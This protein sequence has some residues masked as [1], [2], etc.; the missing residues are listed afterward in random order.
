M[1]SFG[2]SLQRVEDGEL[3]RGA[4]RFVDDHDPAREALHLVVARSAFAH[5]RV[6]LGAL[7]HRTGIVAVLGP[8]DVSHLGWPQLLPDLPRLRPLAVGVTR[9]QGEPLAAVVAE[10]PRRGRDAVMEIDVDYDVL[11]A[12]PDVPR[13]LVPGAPLV[14]EE[15]GSNIVYRDESEERPAAPPSGSVVVRREFTFPRIAPGMLEG[16]AFLAVPDGDGL[17]VYAGHQNAH[18][19]RAELATLLGL[20]EHDVAVVAPAVGG[21]FGAKSSFYPEYA[22]AAYA[23]LELGRPVKYVETR[24]EN[25]ML[26][27]HG[28]AQTQRVAVAADP[29]GRLVSLDVEVDANFGAAADIQ[30]WCIALTRRMLSGAYRIPRITWRM[31]GVLTHTAPLGAFRGAGRPE[32]AYL[33][34]RIVDELAREL[35]QDPVALRMANFVEP[36]AFPYRTP[37]GVTYDSGTYAAALEAAVEA[38][39]YHAWTARR[40]RRRTEGASRLLGVGVASYV[41]MTASGGEYGSVTLDG[42][43]RALVRTGTSPHG[44]GHETAWAQVVCD[45]LGLRPE[46]VSV[47][48]GD[49][50]HIPRGGGTSGSRSASLGGSAAARAA[51]RLA[52]RLRELAAARLEA[53]AAD[54]CLEEGFA[55]V[56]GTDIGVEL[57]VLVA[58]TPAGSVTE[59]ADFE[60]P[61]QTFPFGS[62]ICVVEVD[63][64]TGEVTVQA[65]A[66]VDDCGRV[67][68]P[69][70]VEG[71][72][73]G[74]RLQGISLALR[75][76][77]RYDDDGLLLSGN[78]TTYLLPTVR[79]TPRTTTLRTETPSPNNPLGVKGVGEL[80]TTGA[81]PAVANAVVD[82]LG[83]VGADPAGLQIP[84]TPDRVFRALGRGA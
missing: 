10:S 76:Q 58:D 28:R 21:G 9:Y 22:L 62:S 57:A 71:Q 48:Y 40:D 24:S 11:P 14:Y 65:H 49:T 30:R 80:G 55:R 23:A 84:F 4:A 18:K 47:S 72:I 50:R 42:N 59:E 35:G 82:A 5:A 6:C 12:A 20:G 79:D 73:D 51:G 7:D 33:L 38:G 8:D 77:V 1:A 68:N 31:R 52:D 19:L 25:L 56:A 26:T 64:E 46:H 2:R 17:L 83:G 37:T 36:E 67:I 13:A 43:G 32:A 60:A 66:S 16:R 44:Q 78:L 75:E 41:E 15:L 63:T 27:A 3:L 39:D 74:G 69:L 81:T 45:E 61:G 29:L 34:E 54:I 53:A 70:L